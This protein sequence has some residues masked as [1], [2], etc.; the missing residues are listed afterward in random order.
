[1]DIHEIDARARET[2]G[3][4]A[5]RRLRRQGLVP[6]VIY[7]HG[8]PTVLLSVRRSDVEELLREH[9]VIVSVKWDSR[10]ESAQLKAAQLDAL[11]DHVLHLDFVRIS[12]TE[13]VTVSVPVD[14]HGEPPGVDEG[15]VLELRLHEL[16]VQCL[17]AA[18]PEGIRV[19]VGELQIGESL[20]IGDVRFPE[21][22][23]P[24]G[25]P[26]A[27]VVTVTAPMA[28]EEEEEEAEEFPLEAAAEPEVIGRRAAEEEEG[29]EES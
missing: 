29:P 25:E 9:A 15:G 26:E 18:I 28:T 27:V 7:G 14:V 17:P 23:E 6:A 16:E 21:G 4:R 19:E 10:A 13:T 3:S 5:C 8:E 1:M 20:R 22:V 11:G 2:R 24:T 12:L